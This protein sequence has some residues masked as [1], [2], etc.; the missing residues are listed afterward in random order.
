MS[1][2]ALSRHKTVLLN[3]SGRTI[4]FGYLLPHGAS[5]APGAQYTYYGDLIANM[6][7]PSGWQRRSF[8]AF[9][10][11]L[12]VRTALG[13]TT[14][15]ITILQSPTPTLY[16]ATTNHTYQITVNSGSLVA[17]QPIEGSYTGPPGPV[18]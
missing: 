6:C 8:T 2:D 10:T 9:K 5:L 13:E 7:G 3:T 18:F 1:A 17:S 11:D 16:D 15:R 12:G 4:F 14:P